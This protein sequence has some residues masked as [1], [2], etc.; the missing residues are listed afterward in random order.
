MTTVSAIE[1]EGGGALA[2]LSKIQQAALLEIQALVARDSSNELR[3]PDPFAS[4]TP[5]TTWDWPAR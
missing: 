4:E 2:W 1:P 5:F 3:E